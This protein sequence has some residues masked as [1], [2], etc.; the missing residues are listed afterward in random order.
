MQSQNKQWTQEDTYWALGGTAV[1]IGGGLYWYFKNKKEKENE[2]VLGTDTTY[3]DSETSDTSTGSGTG[4]AGQDTNTLPATTTP[5]VTTRKPDASRWAIGQEMMANVKTGT[6]TY[7]TKKMANGSYTNTPVSLKKTFAYGD[8]IGKIIWVGLM[9]DGTYRYVLEEKTFGFLTTLYWVA[10]YR[11]MI[12]TDGAKPI[13]VIKPTTSSNTNSTTTLNAK[14][15]LKKGSKGA[16]VREL[17]KRLGFTGSNIDGDFGAKTLAA[18]LAQ[19][20]V[21][22]ISLAAFA[23]TNILNFNLM[24]KRGSKGAEVIELQKRLGFAGAAADGDFG[25]KTESALFAMKKVKQTTLNQF[26]Y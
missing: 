17:Q 1:A 12:P 2:A 25:V 22:Q 5:A 13:D 9:A 6:P 3:I 11:V 7:E 15:I 4:S 21:S 8:K 20:K 10:D 24:L 16:E 26:S 14:L 18:L 23:T 19:K